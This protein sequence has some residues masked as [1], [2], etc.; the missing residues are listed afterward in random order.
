VQRPAGGDAVGGDAGL[1]PG[2]LGIPC[3]GATS[4]LFR[5]CYAPVPRLLRTCYVAFNSLF[6]AGVRGRPALPA[7]PWRGMQRLAMVTLSPPG[8]ARDGPAGPAGR[9]VRDATFPVFT[10]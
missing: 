9:R 1:N 2:L 10:L 7:T 8:V 5:A 6:L 3:S 4:S